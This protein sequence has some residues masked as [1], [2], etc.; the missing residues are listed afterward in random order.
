MLPSRIFK[1]VG[2]IWLLLAAF[3]VAA[4]GND[5]ATGLLPECR[6]SA[7][8]EAVRA[9]PVEQL[10]GRAYR[11]MIA[12]AE[13]QRALA[14]REHPQVQRL[15]YI[16][17]RLLAPV[18]SCNARALSW[19]WEIN[20]VGGR[21]INAMAMPG[22]KMVVFYG[23]LSELQLSDDELAQIIGHEVAHALLEHLRER[24]AKRAVISESIREGSKLF[25]LDQ[26]D[27]GIV[28]L[29]SELQR[30]KF[31]RDDEAEA[32]H[33][34]M[35]LAVLA[36]YD[37]RASITLW[38]KLGQVK[39]DAEPAFLSTHPHSLAR[40]KAMEDRLPRTMPV[41]EAAAKPEQRFQP[42]IRL[43]TA[44]GEN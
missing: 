28:N 6:R 24:I 5:A 37:P 8:V 35:A 18:A 32:D 15:V 22:G 26:P 13:S 31:S 3:G 2:S 7:F 1:L 42:P 40:V 17:N 20:L 39:A 23:L 27:G 29:I 33:L 11:D 16:T 30:L 44:S 12:R 14:P 9:E 38:Q 10:A 34:G 4:T 25:G 41:F 36:G 19:K 43:S 21:Q